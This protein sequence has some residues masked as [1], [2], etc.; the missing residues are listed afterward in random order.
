MV[1]GASLKPGFS[2]SGKSSHRMCFLLLRHFALKSI[3]PEYNGIFTVTL[4]CIALKRKE[5]NKLFEWQ[6]SASSLWMG[7]STILFGG[8]LQLWI[9]DFDL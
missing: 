6:F 4:K 5:K 3:S 1:L 7:A 9:I 2:I 8:D